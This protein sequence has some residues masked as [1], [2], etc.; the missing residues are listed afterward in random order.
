MKKEDVD[1]IKEQIALYKKYRKTLQYGDFY[2]LQEG[3]VYQW[4]CVDSDQNTAVTMFLQKHV[5]ANK[6]YNKLL[7]RGLDDEKQ[8]HHCKICMFGKH[9]LRILSFSKFG[10]EGTKFPPEKPSTFR[11]LARLQRHFASYA[12]P[13]NSFDI[14]FTIKY[15][16]YEYRLLGLFSRKCKRKARFSFALLSFF[17]TFATKLSQKPRKNE[18][19]YEMDACRHPHHQR[20]HSS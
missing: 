4:S 13:Q 2:R 6:F 5:E 10:R 7:V 19:D 20:H 15:Y 1:A 16:W 11:F 12:A 14:R 3:N 9:R 8:Y 17:R 18:K